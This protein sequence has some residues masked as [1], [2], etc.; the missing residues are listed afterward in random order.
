[1][2]RVRQGVREASRGDGGRLRRGRQ[3]S[4]D[5]EAGNDQGRGRGRGR[6]RGG[7]RWWRCGVEVMAG[8]KKDER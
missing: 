7:V 6:G 3:T 8:D 5:Q 4:R 2:R 1:M